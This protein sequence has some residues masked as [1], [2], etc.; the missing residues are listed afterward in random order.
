MRQDDV[1]PEPFRQRMRNALDMV[2]DAPAFLAKASK[3][4]RSRLAMRPKS[5]LSS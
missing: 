5:T 1:L 4:A 3:M 2:M